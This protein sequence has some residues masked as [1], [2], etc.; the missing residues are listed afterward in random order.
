[1]KKENSGRSGH[2]LK[3]A[4][5]T[6]GRTTVQIWFPPTDTLLSGSDASRNSP[7]RSAQLGSPILSSPSSS[8]YHCCLAFFL[9]RPS[10]TATLHHLQIIPFY[11]FCYSLG[12]Y[13]MR[14]F[15]FICEM[16]SLL[17]LERSA[18]SSLQLEGSPWS[19]QPS[20]APDHPQLLS[21]CP[22]QGLGSR[23]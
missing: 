10:I 9:S 1:M 4:W 20:D 7:H 6:H 11:S 21:S 5:L 23:S 3:V 8:R 16:H 2:S 19:I 14:Y 22:G 12:P 18:R 13:R 15:E 17:F